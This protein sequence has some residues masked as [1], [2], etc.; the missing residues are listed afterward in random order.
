[1]Q[2]RYSLSGPL[3]KGEA[4]RGVG[5]GKAWLYA[6]M[7]FLAFSACKSSKPVIAAVEM[8]DAKETTAFFNAMRDQAFR[9][10][11]LSA[12]TTMEIHTSANEVSS[13]VDI[14]MVK[15]SAFQLSAQPL[16]GFEVFRMEFS[17]DSLKVIDRMNK[18]F[19]LESYAGLK[20]QLPL[21]FNFYNLQALF[22]NRLFVPGEQDITPRQYSRFKL[23]QDGIAAEA[24]I[25]DA[26][27]LY[28]FTADGEEKLLSTRISDPS[29]RYALQC[30][31]MDFRL[32][33]GQPFP[34]QMDMQLFVDDAQAGS[35]KMHF[36][37]IQRDI[38]VILDFPIPDKYKR[39][40]F[41]E[42]IKRI[43]GSNK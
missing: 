32:T 36:S 10:R 3:L 8:G 31:Y 38:P 43:A 23:K 42:M 19:V 35:M 39:I 12:R 37:R 5:Q 30:S 16:P 33:E 27:L 17:T 11:T 14:K 21:D 24:Q 15:D 6:L 20:G 18:L 26:L 7:L 28:T 1:M 9:F 34:A 13:R 2:N 29:G 25:K 4:V 40:T 41:A 22:T